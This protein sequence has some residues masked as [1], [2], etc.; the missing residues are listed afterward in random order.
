VKYLEKNKDGQYPATR[1]S[2]VRVIRKVKGGGK[3]GRR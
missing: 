3:R 2:D 1:I